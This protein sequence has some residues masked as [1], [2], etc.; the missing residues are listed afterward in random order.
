MTFAR[1]ADDAPLAKLKCIK[2]AINRGL[3]DKRNR[4]KSKSFIFKAESAGRQS[5]DGEV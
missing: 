2:R 3:S 4:Q 1:Q 5:V